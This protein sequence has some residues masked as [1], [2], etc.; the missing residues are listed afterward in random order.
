MEENTIERRYGIHAPRST[1]QGTHPIINP[2][3]REPTRIC[4]NTFRRSS[5]VECPRNIVGVLERARVLVFRSVFYLP[6]LESTLNLYLSA[7]HE[8]VRCEK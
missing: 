1:E 4:E 7:T 6:K 5:R 3:L 8:N 2:E